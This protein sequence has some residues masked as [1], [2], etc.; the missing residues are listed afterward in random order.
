[1]TAGAMCCMGSS[2]GEG[3]GVFCEAPKVGLGPELACGWGRS[4]SELGKVYVDV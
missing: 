1:M 3:L 2:P 4:F